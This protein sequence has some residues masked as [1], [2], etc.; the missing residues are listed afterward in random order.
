M[1]VTVA[2]L[3]HVVKN[4][5]LLH[6]F[7]TYPS[8]HQNHSLFIFNKSLCIGKSA[9]DSW[10]GNPTPFRVSREHMLSPLSSAVNHEPSMA[11]QAEGEQEVIKILRECCSQLSVLSLLRL[12]VLH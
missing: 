7:S 3:L 6:H 12:S 8:S 10:V 5:V 9:A 2:F 1:Q 4:G 11:V